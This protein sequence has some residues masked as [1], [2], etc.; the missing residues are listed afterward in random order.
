[1]MGTMNP[2]P[3]LRAALVVVALVATLLPAGSATADEKLPVPYSFLPAAI[4]AGATP[5]ANAP[6]TNDWSCRPSKR[7]PRPVV[8]VHGLIGNRA[9]NWPTYGPLLKNNGYCVFALTY[10]VKALP[11]PYKFFG[12]LDRMQSS[13]R[14]VKAFVAKVL[15]RTGAREVDIVGHS[16]GT[17]VPAYYVKYLGGARHVKRYVAIAGAYRGTN[18]AG[19][20][21]V[22]SFG[23]ALGL[24]PAIV[25]VLEPVFASGPQLLSGSD[26]MKKLNRGGSARTPGVSYTNIITR[27]DELVMPSSSGTLPGARNI[28]LQDVCRL[29]LSDHFQ[30]VSSPVVAAMV[31]NTLD[32]AHPRKVPCRLVLPFVGP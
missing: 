23:K 25:D 13:A 19:L 4:L 3:L 10:G 22:Y 16:E 14:E 20:A 15:R 8:L 6:G 9:T 31:L 32:P 30:I 27:Y 5:G 11:E 28:L 2:R 29:D 21:T 17:V 24:T 26:F 7:H 12:G 1:M 18:V